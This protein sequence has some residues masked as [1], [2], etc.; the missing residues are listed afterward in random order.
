MRPAAMRGA[1]RADRHGKQCHHFC[2]LRC[3]S[4]LTAEALLLVPTSAT[5]RA[6]VTCLQRTALVLRNEVECL[7]TEPR[8]TKQ[9]KLDPHH[10][11]APLPHPSQR[12]TFT[13]PRSM[14]W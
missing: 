11:L 4:N 12:P 1:E 9:E 2:D 3:S 13:L 14:T 8:Q 10:V 5:P 6:N 7:E